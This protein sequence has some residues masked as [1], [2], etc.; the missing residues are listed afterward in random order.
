ML[1]DGHLPS[2]PPQRRQPNKSNSL[3]KTTLPPSIYPKQDSFP[4]PLSLSTQQLPSS[5]SFHSTIVS[6]SSVNPLMARK[7]LPN[8]C[9]HYQT[10]GCRK[11]LHGSSFR[12]RLALLSNRVGLHQRQ[13]AKSITGKYSKRHRSNV[14][15]IIVRIVFVSSL[16]F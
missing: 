9:R 14:A 5:I 10:I 15:V 1:C 6:F 8:T 7:R 11:R 12:C 2:L 3:L 4:F 13:D 16:L